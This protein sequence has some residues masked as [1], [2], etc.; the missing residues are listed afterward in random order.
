MKTL[1]TKDLVR[2]IPN[3]KYEIKASFR[4]RKKVEIC[5]TAELSNHW[6]SNVFGEIHGQ[7]YQNLIIYTNRRK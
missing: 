2:K 4:V 1:K 7:I 3:P 5:T 6:I